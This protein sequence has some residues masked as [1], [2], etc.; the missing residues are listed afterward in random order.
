MIDNVDPTKLINAV[1]VK[2][3]TSIA[4]PEWAKFIKTGISKQRPP[5]EED[6]WQIRAASILRVIENRGPVG[7]AKLRTK[8]GGRKNRGMKPE[9]VFKGAGKLIRVILQQ[10]EEAK[11]IEKGERGAH[12][13]RVIT[14]AG[15]TLLF[16]TAKELSASKPTKKKETTK[17]VKE[18]KEIPKI[19]EVKEKTAEVAKEKKEVSKVSE[20]KEEVAE[21]VKE[22]KEVP[23]V[24]EQKEEVAEITVE[25]PE[26]ST[27]KVVE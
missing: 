26:A 23:K 8:Y 13:G 7:V 15:R 11:L 1:A 21:I 3:K 12:K 16:S 6:W 25:K 18:K 19:S 2:L 4:M 27:K 5:T 9:H 14:N 17:V 20:Q 24:S 22:K 10:L